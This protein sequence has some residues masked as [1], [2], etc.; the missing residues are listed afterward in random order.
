MVVRY[1]HIEPPVLMAIFQANLGY[2]VV[3]RFSVSSCLYPVHDS[4]RPQLCT[5]MVIRATPWSLIFIFILQGF[6][7]EVFTGQMPFMLPNQQCQSTEGMIA[8]IP[9]VKHKI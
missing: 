9:R 2:Q 1:A 5:Y 3:P 8:K 4:I 6:E 7:A